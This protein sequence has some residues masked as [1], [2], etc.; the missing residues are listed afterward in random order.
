MIRGAY[1]LPVFA[2]FFSTKEIAAQGLI[3]FTCNISGFELRDTGPLFIRGTGT[4]F[5][6]KSSLRYDLSIPLR[7]DFPREAHFH[8]PRVNGV[9]PIIG[10]APFSQIAGGIHYAG[11]I[12]VPPQNMEDL[13]AGRWYVNLHS[14][15]YENGVL[16]GTVVPASV[17]EPAPIV[18]GGLGVA[19]FCGSKILRA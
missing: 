10:L 18:L 15:A 6:S 11:S 3:R 4:L 14:T 19:L 12:D 8:G 17:P 16:T 1:L 5:L 7:A 2:L 13:L 9:D